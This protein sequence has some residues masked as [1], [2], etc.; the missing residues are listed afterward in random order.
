LLISAG[1]ASVSGQGGENY[2][3]IPKMTGKINFDGICDEPLWD[4]LSNIPMTM[5]KPNHGSKP[6]ERS[7]IFVTF[8]D[9]YLFIGARLSY[10]NGSTIRSTT[11]KK[12][13]AP[14]EAAI[15]SASCSTLSM[16]MKTPYVL[17]P[18]LQD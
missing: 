4:N 16:T 17:R 18:I 9:E 5:F 15:I 1:T 10:Q 7:D 12:G 3:E 8:D 2:L 11:K 13:M 6:T 14:K